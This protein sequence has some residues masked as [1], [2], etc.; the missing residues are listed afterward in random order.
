MPKA[1]VAAAVVVIVDVLSD[2][3]T[4][5]THCGFRVQ[6]YILAFDGAPEA[7]YPYIIKTSGPAIHADAYPILPAGF[8]P[9]LAGVLHDA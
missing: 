4:Q 9:L 6:V 2:A 5:G 8:V 3:V 1:L 7:F